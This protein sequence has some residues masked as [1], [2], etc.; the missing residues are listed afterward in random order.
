MLKLLRKFPPGEKNAEFDITGRDSWRALELVKLKDV[1]ILHRNL[2]E[3]EIEKNQ[4]NI[5]LN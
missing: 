4:F 1:T 2:T 5:E 3:Q